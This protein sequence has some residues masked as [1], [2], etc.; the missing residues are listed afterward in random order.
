MEYYITASLL[1]DFLYSPTSI[2]LHGVYQDFDETIYK[3]KPQVN[4]T[5]NHLAI[6]KGNYSNSKWILTGTMFYSQNYGICGKIDIFDIKKGL[7][8]E[9]KSLV[10]TMHLGYIYQLY[11]Q[12][13]G[14]QEAGYIVKKLEIYSMEDNKTYPVQI[15]NQSQ[16]HDF[17]QL[18]EK[19][20]NFNPLTILNHHTDQNTNISI[21]SNLG[22]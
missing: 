19:I 14:L 10:K 5:I 6:D 2:Y 20:K 21:Y 15:P 13:F 12:M 18:I 22:F 8:R 3:D 4:G 11:A 17:A 16:I 1:N 9:R 7:L